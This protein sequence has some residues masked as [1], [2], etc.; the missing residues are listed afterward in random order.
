MHCAC[1]KVGHWKWQHHD[2]PSQIGVPCSVVFSAHKRNQLSLVF[3]AANGISPKPGPLCAIISCQTCRYNTHRPRSWF[4]LFM[5]MLPLML[6]VLTVAIV[7]QGESIAAVAA[8]LIRG[9]QHLHVPANRKV[10]LSR[11]CATTTHLLSECCI[12]VQPVKHVAIL[13]L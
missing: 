13:F 5:F 10:S 3:N 11:M 6:S 9:V 1:H 8:K 2:T 7:R 4:V 12:K